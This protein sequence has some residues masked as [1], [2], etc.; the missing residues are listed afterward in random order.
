MFQ[1]EYILY[2][3]SFE[4]PWL[5]QLMVGITSLGYRSFIILFLA[6]LLF[7]IDFRKGFIIMQTMLWTVLVTVFLKEYFALPRPYHVDSR[8]KLLD[9]GLASE[10]E[11]HFVAMG[12]K[13][14]W[15]GIPQAVI[16]YY[17][18]LSV[19][20]PYG[21]PSG[22]T[23]MAVAIWGTT[24][25][26]FR[27]KWVR[28]ICL[29]LIVLVPFSRIYLGVHFL[30]DVLGGYLIGIV[31]F[32]LL[33][34][35]VLKPKTLNMYLSARRFP[36]KQY[37]LLVLLLLLS[38]FI[39]LPFVEKEALGTLST[40]WGMNVAFVYLMQRGLPISNAKIGIRVL[41]VLI[42]IALFVGITALTSRALPD[43]LVW[44]FV[45]GALG[46]I[47]FIGVSTEVCIRLGLFKQVS[48][49]IFAQEV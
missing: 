3:Q 34:L 28:L 20:I 42:G 5:T 44:K 30:A 33:Y 32:W 47:F 13:T 11:L 25:W 14:F 15:E 18:N 27:P 26:L 4:Q 24:A 16:N 38:P 39:L 46:G 21:F 23:S 17:R 49:E 22:H 29:L 36:F 6:V 7:G 2:F 43:T 10:R 8:V 37:P 35:W 9:G 41:R 40:L 31:L 1:T 48:S 45:G 19:G 12:A